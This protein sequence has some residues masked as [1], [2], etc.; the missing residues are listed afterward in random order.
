[1]LA[2]EALAVVEGVERPLRR[3]DVLHCPSG[4]K[5]VIVGAVTGPAWCS[6]SARETVQGATNGAVTRRTMPRERQAPASSTTR[7]TRRWRTRAYRRA[8][9]CPTARLASPLDAGDQS[10][11]GSRPPR[12]RRP[13]ARARARRAVRRTAPTRPRS[14]RPCTPPPS[15]WWTRSARSATVAPSGSANGSSS[16]L[17][18]ARGKTRIS[19]VSAQIASRSR[20]RLSSSSTD[21]ATTPDN[22]C[23][24]SPQAPCTAT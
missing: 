12:R 15:S 24:E 17:P 7:P 23:G 20:S 10:A 8:G 6:R 22:A 16:T 5:H 1:M 18:A 3:W 9:R 11:S 14:A 2:G 21:T 19:P 4:T 13:R